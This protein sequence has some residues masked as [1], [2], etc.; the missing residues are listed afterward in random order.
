VTGVE[1]RGSGNSR[2]VVSARGDGRNRAAVSGSGGGQ[3]SVGCL[4]RRGDD[5]LEVG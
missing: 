4:F 3:A 2:A 1:R 5:I